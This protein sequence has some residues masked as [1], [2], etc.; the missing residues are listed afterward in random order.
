[1]CATRLWI[2]SNPVS[3]PMGRL[4]SS[5]RS[6]SSSS[7]GIRILVVLERH[8]REYALG[9][10]LRGFTA[11]VRFTLCDDLAV[12]AHCVPVPLFVQPF[13]HHEFF[14][15]GFHLILLDGPLSH[16][17]P[18]RVTGDQCFCTSNRP[19]QLFGH[20]P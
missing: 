2:S 6:R 8:A 12:T 14:R 16:F 3:P 19:V 18:V 11:R 1:M 17:M 4:H 15:V 9:C 10:G 13:E 7:R 5:Q 20:V